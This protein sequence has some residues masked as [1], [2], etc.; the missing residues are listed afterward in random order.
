MG[1]GAG[2]KFKGCKAEGEQGGAVAE[3]EG[4]AACCGGRGLVMEIRDVG[5]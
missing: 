2:G 1:G 4:F 3:E 5:D